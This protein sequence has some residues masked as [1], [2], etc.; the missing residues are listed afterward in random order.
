MD[1]GPGLLGPDTA[2][3]CR[4]GS[5]VRGVLRGDAGQAHEP[6]RAA[7]IVQVK[8]QG[9]SLTMC[10]H[11]IPSSCWV[12]WLVICRCGLRM[13]FDA[14]QPASS[15]S[16]EMTSAAYHSLAMPTL[17]V[18]TRLRESYIKKPQCLLA[19]RHVHGTVE[20]SE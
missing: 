8:L 15:L 19:T 2:W 10:L 18:R 1:C 4:W 5:Q 16:A 3:N 12:W 7:H 17:S 14:T 11:G 9:N 20:A 13:E 6:V